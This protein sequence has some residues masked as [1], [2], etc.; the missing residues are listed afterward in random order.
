MDAVRARR[1]GHVKP[2]ID[3]DACGCRANCVEACANKMEQG[4]PVEVRLAHLD[5]MHAR[6]RGSGHPVHETTF[7]AAFAVR[8]VAGPVGN[9]ADDRAHAGA[10]SA[11]DWVIDTIR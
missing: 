5:Q 9:H 11:D 2:L 3:D 4:S 8:M 6:E 10:Y 7:P 1:K